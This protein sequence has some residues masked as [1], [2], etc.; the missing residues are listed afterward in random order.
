MRARLRFFFSPSRA[1]TRAM[2]CE[3]GSISSTGMNGVEQF[4]LIG[5]GA[6]S[7]ADVHVEAALF[8]A[9]FNAR[10]GDDAEIV[11]IASGR[12]HAARSR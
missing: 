2:A 12:R 11:K 5:N 7:A 9:V 8:L 3:S 1:K 4:G 6:E 10:G